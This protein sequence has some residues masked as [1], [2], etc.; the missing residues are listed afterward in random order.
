M[1]YPST[2]KRIPYTVQFCALHLIEEAVE[3]HVHALPAL[4][5]DEEVLPVSIA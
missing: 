4:G 5:V 1:T 3:V 2:H